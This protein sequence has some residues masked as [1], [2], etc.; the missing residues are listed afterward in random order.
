M[1]YVVF[2]NGH[3]S[4]NKPKNSNLGDRRFKTD[5]IYGLLE[6]TEIAK[7]K[8]RSNVYYSIIQ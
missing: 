7:E 6:I 5:N 3:V 1:H 8:T 2:M 4:D